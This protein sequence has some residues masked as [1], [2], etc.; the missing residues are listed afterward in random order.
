[1][2]FVRTVGVIIGLDQQGNYYVADETGVIFVQDNIGDLAVG[3]KVEILGKGKVD[4]RSS[5]YIRMI[6]DVYTVKK[7]DNDNHDDPLTYADAAV[8]DFDFTITSAN[9]KTAVPGEELYGKGL[10]FEGY[11]VLVG[12]KVYLVDE[13]GEDAQTIYVTDQSKSIGSLK[14][15]AESKVTLK[16]LVY[17]SADEGWILG[18]LGRTG[19]LKLARS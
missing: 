11:I 8:S 13:L 16:I 17:G 6:Y 3:N 10:L 7:V 4:N 19:D 18:F 9:I 2:D 5:K 14:S 12:D 1:M 15:L